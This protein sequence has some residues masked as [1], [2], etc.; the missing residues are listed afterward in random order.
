MVSEG[1]VICKNVMALGHVIGKGCGWSGPRWKL[2]REEYTSSPATW[3]AL[4]GREGV[5]F[6]CPR[7]GNIIA[8]VVTKMS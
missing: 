3:R 1:I 6:K 8:D 2:V 4:A 7:C 5:L